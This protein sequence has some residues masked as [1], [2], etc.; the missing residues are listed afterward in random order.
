MAQEPRDVVIE[1]FLGYYASSS[2]ANYVGAIN[3]LLSASGK[4]DAT[5]LTYNDYKQYVVQDEEYKTTR[6]RY[7]DSFF[8]YLF[9]YEKLKH[10]EGFRW[11]KEEWLRYYNKLKENKSAKAFNKN[12]YKAEPA[13]PLKKLLE[14]LTL[15]GDNEDDPELL[16]YGFEWFMLF[17]TDC[18]VDEVR[19]KFKAELI[20]DGFYTSEN[21]TEWQIPEK[22]L[23]FINH[24]KKQEK[25]G[26]S[27]LS[28]HIKKLGERVGIENLMPKMI[29]KARE[30]N[31]I[32]CSNCGNGF[33]NAYDNWESV[34]FRIVCKPCSDEIKK[35]GIFEVTTLSHSDYRME[36]E[37]TKKGANPNTF[38]ELKKKMCKNVD[39]LGLHKY[40]MEI[41]E[42]GEAYVYDLEFEKLKGTI[43]QRMIDKEK[44]KDNSNGYDILS[45]ER[46]GT[47]LHIEVKTTAGLDKDFFITE[48][49]LKTAETMKLHG[50]K[51][52][53]YRVE[54]ILTSNKEEIRC[55]LVT[56]ITNN[57]MYDLQP[58]TWVVSKKDE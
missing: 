1:E 45:Y 21:G 31:V 57:H 36:Y 25:S 43:Y 28:E 29:T 55:E 10:P 38:E 46:D 53:I 37:T 44:A 50:K 22:Y 47:E 26:L 49:E 34:S 15:L 14:I 33:S 32:T 2:R 8:R 17:E 40:Q 12:K 13:I 19:K 18:Q 4:T 3:R 39:Y 11:V 52:V 30:Q 23:P 42:L 51:Y 35:K 41:G 48:T 54:N 6:D 5:E 20:Q 16:K 7:L 9:A 56:D 58:R 24:L 27:E